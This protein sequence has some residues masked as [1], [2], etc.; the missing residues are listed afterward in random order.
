MSRKPGFHQFDAKYDF[1]CE[2]GSTIDYVICSGQ[3]SGGHYLGHLLYSTGAMGYP[4]EY[5]NRNH[6]ARWQA[7][8]GST[9]IGGV[10]GYIRSRRTSPN[11]CFGIKADFDQF[12]SA[13]REY[14]FPELFPKTRFIIIHRRD[15]LGQAIS[16]VRARQTNQWISLHERTGEARYDRKQ[17]DRAMLYLLEEKA[18]WLRYLATAGHDRLD[19]VYESL[20]ENPA[21]TVDAIAEYLGV[22]PVKI[23]F[24]L[25][26]PQKQADEETENWRQRFRAEAG[27]LDPDYACSRVSFSE[28][29]QPA[30]AG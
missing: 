29:T 12:A 28:K 3:R 26:L 11:G 23:R 16:L 14:R 8:S 1:V 27:A 15:L 4:L 13:V 10:I 17:I 6:L 22:G 7:L 18:S 9:E 19:V 5:F 30:L 24:D 2:T 25:V 20:V 21:R